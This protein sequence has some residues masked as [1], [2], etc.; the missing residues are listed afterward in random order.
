[1]L[2]NSVS[3]IGLAGTTAQELD[4][5]PT[6]PDLK[7]WTWEDYT[8]HVH[9]KLDTFGEEVSTKALAMYPPSPS[10]TPEYAFTSLGSDL[11]VTCPNDV[12]TAHAAESF[13]SNVWRYVVTSQPSVPVNAIGVPFASKYSFHM[14]DYIAFSGFIS[15][16][17]E[18]PSASDEAFEQ[19]MTQEILS[20]VRTGL[21]KTS[22]WKPYPASVALFNTSTEVSAGFKSKFC[23]YWLKNSFFSY[24]WIN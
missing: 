24:A 14:W 4:F 2:V 15:H 17:I 11:R 21:V 8:S 5:L 1:M 7:S 3:L 16:Y 13:K 23:D 20:F 19:T 22:A 12:M 18:K 10:Y 6:P 9:K